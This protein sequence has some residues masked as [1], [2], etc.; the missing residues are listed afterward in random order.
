MEV[1]AATMMCVGILISFVIIFLTKALRWVWLE[2]KRAERFL[3]R[4]GIK[5]NPYKFFF[6]DMKAM[7]M[8]LHQ[9][10]SKPI[11]I[12]DDVASRLVPFQNQLV[13]ECGKNSFFWYGPKIAVNIMEPEAIKEILNM[14]ND[15]P[16]PTLNPLAKLLIT[17]LVDLEGDKWSKH[18][19]IINPAF[20]LVKLKLVLPAMYGSCNQMMKEWKMLVCETGSCMVD[21]WPFLNNLTADVISRTAFGSNYEEGKIVFQLLKE[22]AQLT[23]K[24]FQSIYIPGWRFVPTKLNKRMK[25]IDYEIGNVLRGIIQKQEGI[26]KTCE[27]SNDN[28]LG[29]LLESNQKE[30][31]DQGLKK[32]FGMNTNDVIN[33]CKL[34]YFAG[35]ETTSVLLNWTMVLLSRFPKWQTL[36]REEIIEIF[37]TKEPDYDGL[38]RLK[39]VTMILY[40]VLRLYPPATVITRVIRKETTVGDMTLPTGALASIPI[41]LVHHDFELWGSDA[42]EFKPERFSEGISK[43]T[44]GKVSFIPFGWGPRIC[45]GQNFALL[46]AKMALSLILQN[47]KFE[48]SSSYVHAPITV[49]TAQPQFGTHLMLQKL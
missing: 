38:N 16:K 31:E 2:P 13:K 24:V 19:K 28:L 40:E 45:I 6:G 33:E 32:D 10:Q 26:M 8:M 12:D 4:Q 48:L 1:D 29:L 35:Q 22:Q 47:F 42:K 34:F 17:G 36:A 18:R 37:G 7:G 43:A 39:V 30:I 20:N 15:F 11:Q 3:R 41:V 46:E 14:I 23:S 5:G 9:A 49:I 25:K 27:A 21:V 44:N